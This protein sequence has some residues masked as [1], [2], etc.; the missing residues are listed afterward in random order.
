[1]KPVELKRLLEWET[2]L[3]S[4]LEELSRQREDLEARF[5]KVSRKLELVRQM[6]SLEEP[7]SA[8]DSLEKQKPVIFENRATPATVRELTHKILTDAAGPLHINDIHRHFLDKG[9][10]IPG[11]GTPFNI[12]VHLVNDKAFVR[13]ARGTYAIAGT[14]P[15]DQVLARAPKTRKPRKSK[16]RKSHV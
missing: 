9:Y 10:P 8:D 16:K 7:C 11:A 15:E 14:V 6:R 4:E 3:S 1:M 2:L 13:V 5:Q 12:L